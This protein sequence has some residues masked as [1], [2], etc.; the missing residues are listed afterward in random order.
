MGLGSHRPSRAECPF[1]KFQ[2]CP[3]PTVP[4]SIIL[5]GWSPLRSDERPPKNWWGSLAKRLCFELSREPANQDISDIGEP[6]HR[7]IKCTQPPQPSSCRAKAAQAFFLASQQL[8]ASSRHQPQRSCL[9]IIRG[10]RIR[11]LGTYSACSDTVLLQLPVLQQGLANAD[12]STTKG[13]SAARFTPKP[14]VDRNQARQH[15]R[16][17]EDDARGGFSRNLYH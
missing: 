7:R 4:D 13:A 11:C 16:G 12:P 17:D 3:E 9:P 10:C 6:R 5:A 8:R 2:R 1:S 14:L 15:T